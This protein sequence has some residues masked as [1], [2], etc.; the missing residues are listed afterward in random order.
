MISNV[1][2][3][4]ALL[5]LATGSP[6]KKDA[7]VPNYSYMNMGGGLTVGFFKDNPKV[8]IGDL[9]VAAKDCSTDTL[10]CIEAEGIFIAVPDRS[11]GY[12]ADG[13]KVKVT[14]E[15]D[16]NFFGLQTHVRIAEAARQSASYRSWYSSDLGLLAFS[17]TA[18]GKT[19]TYLL[20]QKEGLRA[21]SKRVSKK[22]AQK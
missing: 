17:I 22:S 11:V 7:D 1:V 16:V 20:S 3:A 8:Q 4:N 2:I 10:V 13:T 15:L 12:A 18:K 5:L 19:A 21:E 9:I 6:L 14:S